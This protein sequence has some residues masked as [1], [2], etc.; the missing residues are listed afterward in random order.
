MS[1]EYTRSGALHTITIASGPSWSIRCA[2]RAFR[3]SVNS[4][5]RAEAAAASASA[6]SRNV[7]RSRR[8]VIFLHLDHLARIHQIQGIE[9]AFER[10]HDLERRAVLGLQIFHLSV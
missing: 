6:M 8:R 2:R 3:S 4:L 5:A 9:R 10:P 1:R 7:R